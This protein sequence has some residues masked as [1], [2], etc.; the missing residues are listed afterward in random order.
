MQNHENSL[1]NQVSLG[2]EDND[3]FH[4]LLVGFPTYTLEKNWAIKKN[5]QHIPCDTAVLL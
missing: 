1:K 3:N 2:M 5:F 4:T